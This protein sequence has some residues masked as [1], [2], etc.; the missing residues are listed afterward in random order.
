MAPQPGG[1]LQPLTP[2]QC[3]VSRDSIQ[4]LPKTW[5]LGRTGVTVQPLDHYFLIIR[6]EVGRLA[7]RSDWGIEEEVANK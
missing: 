2:T 5:P 3:L 7:S 4:G 6:S 1:A